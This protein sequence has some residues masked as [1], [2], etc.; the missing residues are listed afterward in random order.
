MEHVQLQLTSRF[1]ETCAHRI[2]REQWP[3]V[4]H[5]GKNAADGPHI[6]RRRVMF[7]T[8]QDLRRPIPQSDHLQSSGTQSSVCVM[9]DRMPRAEEEGRKAAHLMSVSSHWDAEGPGQSEVGQLQVVVL[10]IDEQV[11]RLQI[12]MKYPMHMAVCNALQHLV[13]VQLHV[14][15]TATSAS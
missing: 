12:T 4:D 13:E 5:L 8:Q 15:K 7:G 10:P 2:T 1:D 6:H 3:L 9:F 11:L 14:Q